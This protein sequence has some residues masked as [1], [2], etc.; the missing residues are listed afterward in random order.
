MFHDGWVA[1]DEWINANYDTVLRLASVGF[2]INQFI[3]DFP[4]ESAAIHTPFLNSVSGTDFEDSVANVAYTSLDPFWTFD[5]QT[6]W[7]LDKE[8]PLN[9][10]YVIGS[11][12]R[13][14]EEQELFSPGELTWDR[15]TVAHKV[16]NDLLG[17]KAQ[18]ETLFAKLDGMQLDEEASAQF[19]KAKAYHAAFNFL[20]AHR[21]AQAAAGG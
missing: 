18:A 13:L 10:E 5:A 4:G 15:F 19:E 17:H 9:A 16:Y 6:G 11:A 7:I 20:D 12:I 1:T 8:N 2:R 3:N 14:Y 21:F